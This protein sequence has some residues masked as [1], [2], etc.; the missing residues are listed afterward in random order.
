M[1]R[2]EFIRNLIGLYGLKSLPLELTIERKNC[3]SKRIL[4]EVSPKPK[5]GF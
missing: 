5:T 4:K 3:S 1:N 2:V